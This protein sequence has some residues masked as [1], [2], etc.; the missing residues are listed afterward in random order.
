MPSDWRGAL[1]MY[2]LLRIT[3]IHV[4]DLSQP[5]RPLAE[6][7]E[8]LD[9]VLNLNENLHMTR[10]CTILVS[11]VRNPDSGYHRSQAADPS[12]HIPGAVEGSNK[13]Y[14]DAFYMPMIIISINDIVW[15]ALKLYADQYK[16]AREPC[17]AK[18]SDPRIIARQSTASM[19]K[20]LFR[21][22]RKKITDDSR[23]SSNASFGLGEC[24][25]VR[26]LY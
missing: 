19:K 7:A 22:D 21:G 5:P 25:T 10:A 9:I 2:Q 24:S 11:S 15:H 12:P 6:T 14:I 23:K 17:M 13:V 1:F 20:V 16:H 26:N 8:F 18:N 3:A 4:D